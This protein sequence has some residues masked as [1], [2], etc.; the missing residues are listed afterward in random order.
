MP[1]FLAVLLAASGGRGLSVLLSSISL[2][3]HFYDEPFETLLLTWG[4]FLVATELIKI[5]FGT[6][7]RNVPIPTAATI[8]L[9][10]IALPAY[11]TAVA[12]FCSCPPGRRRSSSS[13]PAR[14]PDPGSDRRTARWRACS[15]LTSAASYKLVFAVGA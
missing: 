8:N 1:F 15:V 11:R 3:R 14:H 9:A 12:G 13:G 6:D 10:A 7:F 4:F 2:I 5:V